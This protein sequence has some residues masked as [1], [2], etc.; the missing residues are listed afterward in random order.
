MTHSA[1]E[2]LNI[3]QPEESSYDQQDLLNGPQFPDLAAQLDL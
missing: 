1:L 3:V 2:G